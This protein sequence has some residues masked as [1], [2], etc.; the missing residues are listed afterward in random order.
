MCLA[1]GQRIENKKK[2]TKESTL[3]LE[4][5]TQENKVAH[6]LVQEWNRG[7]GLKPQTQEN[8]VAR[9]NIMVTIFQLTLR[10]QERRQCHLQQ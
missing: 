9:H 10:A 1:L 2:I 6:H 8:K 7:V 4:P 3:V 5:Q